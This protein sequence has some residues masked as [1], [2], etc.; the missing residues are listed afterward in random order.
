M[1]PLYRTIIEIWTDYDPSNPQIE[2]VHLAQEATDGDAYCNRQ[3]TEHI[4]N[5]GEAGL[6]TEFFDDPDEE[7]E[8]GERAQPFDDP[9]PQPM[10]CLRCG[11]EGH[12]VQACRE[13]WPSPEGDT[14]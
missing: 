11:R 2:L 14:A 6:Q 1:K 4:D 3:V 5:P 9:A 10:I 13:A 8:M 12:G 7:Q